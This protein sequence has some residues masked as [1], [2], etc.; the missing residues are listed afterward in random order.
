[1][2]GSSAAAPA[3]EAAQTLLQELPPAFCGRSSGSR[4]SCD[5]TT[6]LWQTAA[7]AAP[8]NLPASADQGCHPAG[9]IYRCRQTWLESA[10]AHAAPRA[11]ARR[12]VQTH[13][14][15]PPDIA[16]D[17]FHFSCLEISGF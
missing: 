7:S 5:P 14:F 12:P 10:P 8:G 11:V 16:V 1:M 3:P 15:L 17:P 9:Y 6:A 4:I 2:S 13:S